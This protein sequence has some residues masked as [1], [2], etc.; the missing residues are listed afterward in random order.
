MDGTAEP[1]YPV[2]AVGVASQYT[3]SASVYNDGYDFTPTAR[4]LFEEGKQ[5]PPHPYMMA[6]SPA[7]GATVDVTSTTQ[8]IT[9]SWTP[10]T[11]LNNDPVIYQ[12]VLLPNIAEVVAQTNSLTITGQ[13]V[14]GWLGGQGEKTFDWTVRTT[15]QNNPVVH[16]KDTSSVTFV[17]KTTDVDEQSIIPA[18]FFVDQNYPNPFNPT[19][20][21][22]FGLPEAADVNLVVYDMLG[23]EVATLISNRSMN[24]GY[25]TVIFNANALAS[26]HYIYKLTAG[27]KTEIKKMLLLK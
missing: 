26:G 15:D 22:Q 23:R 10:T 2:S 1:V 9:I 20:T 24:A 27:Q 12:F 8:S 7:D 6:Q 14:L 25:H 16:S 4:D 19:T 3:S 5:V 21:I 11:D 13:Q 17:N 18:E